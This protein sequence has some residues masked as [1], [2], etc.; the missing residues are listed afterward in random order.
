AIKMLNMAMIGLGW[1]G[2][3]LVESVQGK[4]ENI[5]FTI[6]ANLEI[7]PALDFA[8]QY[9][10]EL[11]TDYKKILVDPNIDAVVIATPH[12]LH[13]EQIVNAA[14]AGKHIYSEK[15]LALNLKDAKE[16]C[17]VC[18][19]SGVKLAVGHDR[20]LLPGILAMKKIIDLGEI[21]E[22]VHAETQ[23]SNDVMSRGLSGEWR[24]N[25][26]EAPAGGM[27]GPGLHALDTLLYFGIKIKAVDGKLYVK[28][29]FPNP[30]D[31]VTVNL[32]L[33]NGYGSLSTIRG[34]PDYTRFHVLG[35][36]GWVELRDFEHLVHH[37]TGEK[38]PKISSYDPK[39]N[40]S[41]MLESFAKSIREGS[42]FL[43]STDQILLTVSVFE[44]V[45]ESIN[46]HKKVAIK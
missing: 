20:R 37:K 24:A 11:T 35:T 43:V 36:L 30:I 42:D 22:V 46:T 25:I 23:Y 3:T 17:K 8:K 29:P 13:V 27:T 39:M 14:K 38:S 21:G 32:E 41:A 5:R 12:S 44:A 1:W 34:V 16:V 7:P 33:E 31:S 2:K 45:I 6:A 28:K 9:G 19:E 26:N 18:K 40:T 15:P 4:S 10:L